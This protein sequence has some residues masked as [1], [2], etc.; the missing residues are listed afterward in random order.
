MPIY[1]ASSLNTQNKLLLQNLM[2]F[3]KN[4]NYFLIKPIDKVVK[5][6]HLVVYDEKIIKDVLIIS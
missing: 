6:L 5:D 1:N 3:Y 2:D 4:C